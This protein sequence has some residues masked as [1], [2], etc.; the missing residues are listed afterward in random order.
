MATQTNIYLTEEVGTFAKNN[1]AGGVDSIAAFSA[2]QAIALAL[3]GIVLGSIFYVLLRTYTAAMGGNL[4]TSKQGLQ[5]MGL[6]FIFLALVLSVFSYIGGLSF[7]LS[8][9]P[10]GTTVRSD[11][12]LNTRTPG[13]EGDGGGT[14]IVSGDEATMFQAIQANESAAR[15][16]L[17]TNG[18]DINKGPCSAVRASNCTS[19]GGLGPRTIALLSSLM[20]ACACTITITGG[21]EWWLHGPTTKHRPGTASAVDISS[22]AGINKLIYSSS[23]FKKGTAWSICS[24]LFTW[25]GYLFC[26]EVARNGQP[27]H[28]HIQPL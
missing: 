23:D 17:S 28:W 26:D 11:S 4:S 6:A 18:I 21:T 3:G 1:P 7:N 9:T 2:N 19:I 25:N 13:V 15:A 5:R 8:L 16:S 20:N 24:A 22:G 12:G 14:S 10:L 27:G